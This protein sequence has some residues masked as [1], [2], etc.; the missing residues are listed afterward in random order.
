[1]ADL[2]LSRI[3]LSMKETR[4]GCHLLLVPLFPWKPWMP[5]LGRFERVLVWDS[6]TP[7]FADRSSGHRQ[8]VP[9]VED[10]QWAVFRLI[11]DA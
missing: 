7:L 9:M 3:A 2:A 11:K 8:W 5:K 6:F 4:F 1:M 10:V